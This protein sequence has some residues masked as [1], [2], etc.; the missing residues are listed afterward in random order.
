MRGLVDLLDNNVQGVA[1][2]LGRCLVTEVGVCLIVAIKCPFP[3]QG[4]S[5][6]QSYSGIVIGVLS[7]QR[8]CNVRQST[9]IYKSFNIIIDSFGKSKLDRIVFLSQSELVGGIIS[10]ISAFSLISA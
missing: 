1:E 9:S 7:I 8:L 10:R 2:S 6:I 5:D 3:S 4:V